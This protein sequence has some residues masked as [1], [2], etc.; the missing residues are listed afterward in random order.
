MINGKIMIK[1]K[2]VCQKPLAIGRSRSLMTS[3]NCYFSFIEI[4]LNLENLMTK[5]GEV[6]KIQLF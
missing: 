6:K 4:E 1:H 2:T 3:K 5:R